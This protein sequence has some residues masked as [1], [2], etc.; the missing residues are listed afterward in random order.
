MIERNESTASFIINIMP[1]E[2][3]QQQTRQT[4]SPGTPVQYLAHRHMDKVA[5]DP[6]TQYSAWH[7]GTWSPLSKYANDD[8]AEIV[9][10]T[11]Y[12]NALGL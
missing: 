7:T 8:W 1:W 10:V 11:I 12:F 9:K 5:R 2:R 3:I 6:S 4:K